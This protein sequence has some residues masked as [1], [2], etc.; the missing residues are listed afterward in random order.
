MSRCLPH[1]RKRDLKEG[2]Q[3]EAGCDVNEWCGEF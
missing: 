3:E 2:V 1:L